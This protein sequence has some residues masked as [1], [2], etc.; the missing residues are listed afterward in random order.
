MK[1]L[2][3][4]LALLLAFW[5]LAVPALAVDEAGGAPDDSP[6]VSDDASGDTSAPES[7]TSSSD[8]DSSE[9]APAPPEDSTPDPEEDTPPPADDTS[10]SS[11]A[12]SSFPDDDTSAPED[13]PP[14]VE[15]TPPAEDPVPVDPPAETPVNPPVTETPA[16]VP[17]ASPG[18]SAAVQDPLQVYPVPDTSVVAPGLQDV[19]LNAADSAVADTP[20][21]EAPQVFTITTIPE[22]ALAT[23]ESDADNTMSQAVKALFGTYT[24][25]VQTV[26]TY[27]NGEQIA[28]EEQYVPGAAGLDWE[29]LAGFAVFCLMLYCLFRLL[30]GT[31]K[32][33]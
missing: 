28:I 1:K 11:D 14:V 3:P 13:T 17:T 6:P 16:E 26:T 5:L 8:T 4:F 24:P 30:G 20:V 27:Y 23:I 15:D 25:R 18:G 7:E 32:Y 12:P 31:V 29:W 21:V 9:E 19:S 2:R 33:G 22:F 10:S